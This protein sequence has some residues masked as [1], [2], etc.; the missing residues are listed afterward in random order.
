MLYF[1]Y[2]NKITYRNK[3]AINYFL[4]YNYIII[5]G[6]YQNYYILKKNLKRYISISNPFF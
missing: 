2:F 1:P 4:I 5:K 3:K 6:I